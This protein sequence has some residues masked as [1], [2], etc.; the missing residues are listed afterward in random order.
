MFSEVWQLKAHSVFLVTSAQAAKK[1]R[2]A[3]FSIAA[4]AEQHEREEPRLQASAEFVRI[5]VRY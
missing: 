1:K 4:N 2:V 3:L 5:N